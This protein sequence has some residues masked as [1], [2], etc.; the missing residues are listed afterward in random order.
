MLYLGRKV[1]M[2]YLFEHFQLKRKFN[3]SVWYKTVDDKRLILNR[4]RS[5]RDPIRKKDS[6]AYKTD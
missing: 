4:I 5:H 1:G 3:L 6:F 2:R